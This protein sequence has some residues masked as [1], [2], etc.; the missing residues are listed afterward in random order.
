[1]STHL[2][3]IPIYLLT[4]FLHP[5]HIV[6]GYSVDKA[7]ADLVAGLTVAVIL[8]PQA[9]AFALIAELPPQVGLYTAL[10]GA[11]VGA[12]WGSSK[13]NHTGPTSALS[14]LVLSVLSAQIAPGTAQF[15]VAVALISV[16]V[17]VLQLVM[18]IA[19]LGILVNF[20]SDAVIVGFSAG[21][22]IQIAISELRHLLGLTV[23]S[24]SLPQRAIL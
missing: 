10:V 1:M 13:Y 21:A 2:K 16:M 8:L 22:G 15:L 19:R 4:L 23:A 3:T 14:L 9:I 6:R 24:P 20:V 12:L 18:G 7:R 17:G 11:L 5:L